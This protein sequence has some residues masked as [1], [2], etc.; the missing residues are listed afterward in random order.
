LKVARQH[1]KVTNQRKDFQHKLSRI[2]VE[3][4]SLLALEDLHIKGMVRNRRLAKHISDAG[5]GQFVRMLAYKGEW[6]GCDLVSVDR[7]YPSSKTCSICDAEMEAMPLHV[8]NWE[9][10]ICEAAHDRDVNAARNL[11]KQATAGT[12]GSHAGGVH[13]RPARSLQQA[14]TQKPEAHQFIGG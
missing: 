14:G 11:L 4:H 12:A 2:L 8:R 7:W 6:Y 13:V 1:E 9:C 10:P 3:E 5:W